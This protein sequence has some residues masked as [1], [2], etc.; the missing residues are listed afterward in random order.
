MHRA[1]SAWIEGEYHHAPHRGLH[2][3]TPTDKWARSSESVRMPTQTS[4]INPQGDL[5]RSEQRRR[6]QKD[7]TVTLDGVAFEVDT[8]LVG[9]HVTPL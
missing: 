5:F 3:E 4:A 8:A 9:D 6:V 7:R 2:G 1:L